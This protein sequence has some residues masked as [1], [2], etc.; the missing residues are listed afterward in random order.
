M[1]AAYNLTDFEY[2]EEVDEVSGAPLITA[3]PKTVR[4]AREGIPYN[5]INDFG[6]LFL[7]E[8]MREAWRVFRRNDPFDYQIEVADAILYSALNGL[9]WRFVIMVTR[10]AGKNEISAFIQH[11]ILLY[12]WYYGVKVSGIKFAPVY[13]PQVHASMTRLEGSDTSDSGGLAGSVVTK[14]L[15][16]KSEGYKYH[17]GKPRATNQIVFLTINPTAN[18]ASQTAYTLL[19]GDEAQ[20]IDNAKWEKD[21]QPMATFN[22]ATTVFWGVAWTKESHIYKA[23]QEC[24][25][26]EKK[27]EREIGYRPKLVFKIDAHAVIASGNENYKKAFENQVARL[28]VNHIAIQTQYL[29]NFV[30]SIGR[31]FSEEQIARIYNNDYRMRVGPEPGAAYIFSLDVAGQEENMEGSEEVSTAASI[32]TNA[33]DS[34]ALTIGKLERDGTVIPVCFYEWVG[35]AHTKAREIIPKILK[36]WKTVGGS[37]DATGIGES[38]AYYLVEYFRG[39]MEIEPYKFKAAG[40]ENKSKLGYSMYAAVMSD[41]VKI[42]AVP[43]TDD[44]QLELW[45][46][47]RWQLE[48]LIRVAK[49][50]QQINFYVPAKAEPRKPGHIPHDDMAMTIFLLVR[51]AQYVRDPKKREAVA[52]NRAQSGV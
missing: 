51:A 35:L 34:L 48:H 36:H 20:D 9:G 45:R 1:E 43:P 26:L 50:Q 19:E 24:Y 21:A 6:E 12:G 16:K 46:E 10:Q 3:I 4:A 49:K 8:N 7:R 17:I 38:L 30:D 25:E 13:K 23:T 32:G 11:Y 14:R 2:R 22:N 52:V 5:T 18:I 42:P 15:Y 41:L 37:C 47:T 33:R 31:F 39:R 29:L 44:I 27:L 28:G 40:D